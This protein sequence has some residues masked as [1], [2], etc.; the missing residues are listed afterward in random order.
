MTVHRLSGKRVLITGASG[1]IAQASIAAL[2]A[3]GAT[4]TGVDLRADG[5]IIGA[6]VRDPEAMRAA[7]A[8]AVERMGGIDILV[9]CAGVG[10]AQDAGEMPGEDVRQTLDIN[11]MGPWVTTAAALPHLQTSHGHIVTVT[12]MLAVVAIPFASAY[13]ASKH[14]LE[15][16]C[17][18]L[19][20]EYSGRVS[21]TTVR[22]GYVK[23]HIH[24]APAQRGVSLDGVAK[25]DSVEQAAAAIVRACT[26]R[27]RWVT[28][29]RA[30][31]VGIWFGQH[32]P[33]FVEGVITRR[34]GEHR[35]KSLEPMADRS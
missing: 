9:N 6:D 21:V 18:C 12:S 22:P 1:G 35:L 27:P 10:T 29:S 24:D 33:K 30:T 8:T 32:F 34:S 15:A 11:L 2:Q 14:A 26:H 13:T 4:V 3:Q 17:R 28:T 20:I 7:V 23:T 25:E 19:R 31:A 5:D 16:Y